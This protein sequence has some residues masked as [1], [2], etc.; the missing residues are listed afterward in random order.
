MLCLP[1]SLNEL[2]LLFAP[3]FSRPTYQTFR[4]L[5]GGQISQTGL[6]TVTGMLVGARLSGVWHHARAHRFFAHARWSVDQLGLQI[7]AVIVERLTVPGAPVLVAVDDT[8][9]HRLGRKIHA[10]FWHHDATAN[11]DKAAVAWGNNWVVV[12]IVVELPFLAR[13]VCMPVM[14]RCWQ[15]KRKQFGKGK[16]DPERPGKVQLAREMIELLAARLPARQINVVGDAAYASEAWRGVSSRVTVTSRLR[17][18]AVIYKRTPPPTGKKGRPAKWGQRLPSLAKLALDPA[19]S[20]TEQTVRRYGKTETLMLHTI[21]CLWTP[22][23]AETPV[24]VILV[25]DTNKSSGYQ[26][27]LLTTDLNATAAQ[28]VERYADRWPIEVAFEEGKQIFGVGHARNRTC[29]AVERTVPF[30][31]L[32]MNITI[33]WYVASG[34]HPDVVAE[35][36]ARSPWYLSKTTPSFADMLAKL[37]RVIIAAQYHPGQGQTPTPAEIQD[38]QHAWAAAGL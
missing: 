26:I 38:V 21:D 34:H 37:R 18:N 9:L 24:R 25:Q 23:G 5:V 13:S 12:G 10:C 3:C 8:L 15:P 4:A 6:R 31:F 22:L 33:L 28:I 35:H 19:T 36:L 30:Q 1:V 2:L 27:A 7:A 14:F 16:S 32:A 17:A 20:W 11:S 29:K